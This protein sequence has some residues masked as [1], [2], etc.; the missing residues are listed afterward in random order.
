MGRSIAVLAFVALSALVTGCGHSHG[1]D[2]GGTTVVHVSAGTYEPFTLT[3]QNDTNMTLLPG[4]IVAA[5]YDS[6]VPT[7][8]LA[9]GE[10]ATYS[11]GYLPSSITVGATGVGTFSSYTYPEQTLDLGVDYGTDSSGVTFVYHP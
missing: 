1:S 10:S 6:N 9:P 4:P 5:P 8:A 7:I 11:I 2:Y 3:V